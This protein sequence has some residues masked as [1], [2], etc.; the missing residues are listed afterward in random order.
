MILTLPIKPLGL[1]IQSLAYRYFVLP[2]IST[3]YSF[4]ILAVIN[5]L[6]WLQELMVYKDLL[7][8]H[9]EGGWVGL[10][11]ILTRTPKR[12]QDPVFFHP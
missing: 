6:N 11:V 4:L 1:T 12:Y 9:P 5:P 3:R 7:D 8:G 10:S 2:I